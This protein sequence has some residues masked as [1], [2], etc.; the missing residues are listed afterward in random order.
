MRG[1]AGGIEGHHFVGLA[2]T[3]K[4]DLQAPLEHLVEHRDVLGHAQRVPERQDDD[5]GAEPNT[6]GAAAQIGREQEGVRQVVPPV[7]SKVVLGEPERVETGF[8]AEAGLF[9]RI[10]DQ[11]LIAEREARV[12]ECGV[13]DE[14]HN[15][16]LPAV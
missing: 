10:V 8:L 9:P 15:G 4:A 7:R 6:G 5:R 11:S 3:A 12:F 14:S 13:E 16:A 1:S 2:R